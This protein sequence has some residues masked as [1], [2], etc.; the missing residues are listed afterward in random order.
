MKN[1]FHKCTFKVLISV[2][3]LFLLSFPNYLYAQYQKINFGPEKITIKEAFKT[4][5]E[6][7]GLFID[8]NTKSFDSSVRI[9]SLSSV[10]T[11]G[12]ALDFLLKDFGFPNLF[13]LALAYIG[14]FVAITSS[15]F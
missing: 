6:Q 10:K 14:F 8:Y 13:G 1:Y 2:F 11:V 3:S 4:I 12:K 5:E 9:S 15:S 7:T